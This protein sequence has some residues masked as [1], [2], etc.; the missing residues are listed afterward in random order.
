MLIGR[1]SWEL[2]GHELLQSQKSHKG[3]LRPAF[4]VSSLSGSIRFGDLPHIIR[5]GRLISNQSVK[6][7]H[8]HHILT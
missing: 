4:K 6:P 1:G 8:F 5:A 3:P 2:S 7:I